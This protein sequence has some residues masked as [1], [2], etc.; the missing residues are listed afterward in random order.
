MDE[1]IRGLIGLDPARMNLRDLPIPWCREYDGFEA[2]AFDI[3]GKKRGL[4]AYQL[5]GGGYR[6]WV[7][8]DYCTG[9]RTTADAIRKAKEGQQSGFHGIKFKCNLLDDVVAWAEDIFKE[10]GPSFRIVLDP[11]ARFERPAEVLRLSAR[12]EAIGNIQ[13]LEDPVPRWNLR[14]YRLLRE[15]TSIPRSPYMWRC[16]T[17]SWAR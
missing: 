3:M 17:L 2:A 9:R 1:I 4:P 15:K 16:P 8:V 6:D 11:N 12:L 5:L 7:E 14:W 13:C 10:C